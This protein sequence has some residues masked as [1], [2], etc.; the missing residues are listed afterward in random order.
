MTGFG[1]VHR[2]SRFGEIYDRQR[3]CW[4]EEYRRKGALWR[5]MLR[6]DIRLPPG[7]RVLEVGCGNGKAV[8]SIRGED[9]SISVVDFSLEALRLSKTIDT[10]DERVLADARLLPFRDESFD[11]IIAFHLLEHLSP[12]GMVAVVRE[13]GRVLRSG[14]TV[15]VTV[16]STSDM[17]YGKGEEVERGTFV[18]G[19]GI[20]SHFF[21]LEEI[22]ELFSSFTVLSLQESVEERQ[23]SREA[24]TRATLNGVFSKP[25]IERQ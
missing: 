18:K 4:D 23:Y 24:V 15:Q 22:R 20:S 21:T 11:V 12:G 3:E 8:S 25:S 14:G 6:T 16:L 5:G 1:G 10:I 17:R 19:T 13:M 9:L 7:T 2:R